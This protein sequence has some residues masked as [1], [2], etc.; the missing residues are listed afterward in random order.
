MYQKQSN[1]PRANN[2]I[3]VGEVQLVNESGE[4]LGA[5]DTRKALIL[6]Q[7][8]GLDLVEVGPNVVPPVCKIMDL[9]KYLYNQNKKT[10]MN[11][12]GKSKEVKE[13]RFS[14]VIED[15][16]ISHRVKR[17]FEYLEKGHPVKLVM[18]KKGRQPMDLAKEVFNQILTNFT[19]YSSIESEPKYEGN[20]IS[21]TFKPNGK[22][23]NK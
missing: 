19:D 23:E 13:F 7:E 17:A 8:A 3:R 22:T 14:P 6:A 15:G 10:R 2:E 9:S 21:L 4:N 11:K 5:M 1:G 18:Q 12:K 20:R 16:D